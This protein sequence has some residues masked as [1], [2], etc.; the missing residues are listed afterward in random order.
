MWYLCFFDIFVFEVCGKF[1]WFEGLDVI[2]YWFWEVSL[3]IENEYV[4]GGVFI[5]FSWVMI[6]VYCI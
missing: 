3:R 2:R 5:D 1:W 6:V 4:C